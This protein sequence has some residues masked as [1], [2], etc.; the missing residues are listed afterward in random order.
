MTTYQIYFLFPG[1][2]ATVVFVSAVGLCIF[3]F[4]GNPGVHKEC[5]PVLPWSTSR[6]VWCNQLCGWGKTFD[7]LVSEQNETDTLS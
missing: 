6:L 3:V 7:F 1:S 5:C 4:V 2:N